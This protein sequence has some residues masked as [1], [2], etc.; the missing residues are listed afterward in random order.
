MRFEPALEAGYRV[1]QFRDGLSSLRINVVILM[2]LA[3]AVIMVDRV[4][5]P[6]LSATVSPAVRLGVILPIMATAFAMSFL[7]DAANWYPRIMAVLMLIALMSISWIGLVAWSMSEDRVFARLLIALVSIYF[8]LGLRFRLALVLNLVTVAFYALAA[9]SFGMPTTERIQFLGMLLMTSVVCAAG[10]YNLEYAWRRSWLE[11]ELRKEVAL[12]DALTGLHNRRRLDEHLQQVWQQAL[13]EQKPIAMLSSDIDC[14]RAFNDHYGHAAGD[15]ALKAVAGVHARFGRRPFDMAAR[16]GGEEFVI[17][18]FDAGRQEAL[19]LGEE[20][21][22]AVEGLQIPHAHSTAATVLT[23]SIGIACTVPSTERDS[24]GLMQ[25][26][27]QALYAAKHNGRNRVQL[28]DAP[29]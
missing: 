29:H 27:H 10:A 26:A 19:R 14:F 6:A 1:D 23:V 15:E 4:V 16:S 24:A 7:R 2:G 9:E 11:G 5:F 20:I 17:V 13:R 25:G 12:R 22:R 3:S 21:L 8:V 28:L 18:L